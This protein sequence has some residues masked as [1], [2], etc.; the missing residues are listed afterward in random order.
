MFTVQI[1]GLFLTISAFLLWGIGL[2]NREKG[3]NFRPLPAVILLLVAIGFHVLLPAFVPEDKVPD[4]VSFGGKIMDQLAMVLI[5]FGIGLLIDAGYLTAKK[6]QHPKVYWVPGVMALLLALGI[7]ML[8]KG[9]QKVSG[10][11]E[12]EGSQTQAS[13]LLEI[14]PDDEID[15]FKKVFCKYKARYEQAFPSVSLQEDEDLAQ[16]YLVYVDTIF[17]NSLITE[18]KLDTSN[19]DNVESN[20]FVKL[21]D[22]SG[23]NKFE[24]GTAS[25][26]AN[27]PYLNRQWFAEQLQY[28]EVYLMLKNKTP[29][30]KAKVAILDTGVDKNH[31]DINSTF[32]DSPATED[33][34]GH[35]TH[36]AGL[37]GAVTNNRK[38]IGSLNWEGKFIELKGYAALGTDGSGSY[39][40][41]AQAIVDAA[42]EGADV[43]SMSLGGPAPFGAPKVLKDAVKFALKK[44]A[45]VVV[46][47]GNSNMDARFYSPANIPGVICVAATDEN[48]NRAS[49]SNTN[50]S[51]KMPIAAPG[52]NIFSSIPGSQYTSFNGTSMATPI[53]SGLVGIMRSFNPDLKAEDAYQLLKSKGKAGGNAGETGN[54]IQPVATLSS[55][56]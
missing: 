11:W 15:E 50:T 16:Y 29:K 13:I 49:F 56:L 51:L 12:G 38:G 54:L 27:D 18:L 3:K 41:I 42:K 20:E 55:V 48:G 32:G 39:E 5:N 44:N 23:E 26:S 53:V 22:P 40:T 7:F 30:R 47:A 31:E 4:L 24:T 37:A 46:A 36:C 52:T 8:S 34:H 10:L 35:G 17:K 25:Y 14:G 28:E 9:W 33:N 43:I 19:V 6:Y 1:V 45:I 2:V 21:D